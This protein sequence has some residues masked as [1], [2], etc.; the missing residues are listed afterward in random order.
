MEIT[1]NL[2]K[3]TLADVA[4]FI[5]QEPAPTPEPTAAAHKPE[6]ESEKPPVARIETTP[7]SDRNS[8]SLTHPLV[9]KLCGEQPEK[10][11]L[12][13]I[14]ELEEQKSPPTVVE[15]KE[16]DSGAP[17]TSFSFRRGTTKN[18]AEEVK[19]KAKQ[20]TTPV[21][22]E[23]E[24]SK[25]TTPPQQ[26]QENPFLSEA[27]RD[28]LLKVTGTPVDIDT[29]KVAAEPEVPADSSNK[30]PDDSFSFRRK[31]HNPEKPQESLAP[32]QLQI[33]KEVP[34]NNNGS[35]NVEVGQRLMM[36]NETAAETFDEENDYPFDDGWKCAII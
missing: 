19:K 30:K 34:D 3:L 17:G 15:K 35:R 2:E 26:Q 12:E 33:Q 24:A 6:V 36:N 13:P 5:K 27:S 4:K 1:L 29:K 11:Q 18:K 25:K 10:P 16:T 22:P 14:K 20:V 21:A 23:P 9:L 7:Q 31:P 28:N 8:E 32:K